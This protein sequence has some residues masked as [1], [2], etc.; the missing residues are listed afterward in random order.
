MTLK[1]IEDAYLVELPRIADPAGNLTF[2]E[3]KRHVPFE[4]RR[5]F[6]TYDVPGGESRAGH[7]SKKNE[8]LIVA[9]SGSFDVILDDG[10]RHQR[11][12]LNR[13]YFGV[14]V[15]NMIWRE[16]VNFSSGSVCLV[17]ASELFD[18]DDYYRSYDEYRM[19]VAAS[20]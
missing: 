13:S 15:P 9:A 6:Y 3:E 20:A 2:V 16:L 19:A 14:Y 1:S 5:V 10:Q 18:E 12:S 4:I 8:E 11:F 7:A 17:L